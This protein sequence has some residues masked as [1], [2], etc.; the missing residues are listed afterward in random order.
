MLDTSG[1][2]KPAGRRAGGFAGLRV[3]KFRHVYG[4]PAKK[5]RCYDN[6]RLT[7][8][9]LNDGHYAAVNPAFLAVV[10]EVEK[11]FMY[12]QKIFSWWF[13]RS[14][15]AGVSW[16]CRWAGRGGWSTGRGR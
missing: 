1:C 16:W 2:E 11:Y 9:P 6:L 7:R 13:L 15:A 14:A 4:V 12:G 8:S 10:V 3:S 5:E